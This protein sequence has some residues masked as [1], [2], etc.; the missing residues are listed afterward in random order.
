MSQPRI[1]IGSE[2]FRR[3]REE[4]TLY[5]DKTGLIEELL[6]NKAEVSLITRPRRFGKTLTMTMLRD[7]FDIRQDSRAI[8]EGLAI[9]QNKPLCE[10]WMNQYPTVFLTLK[11]VEGLSFAQAIRK[12]H[13]LISNLGDEFSVLQQSPS[14][15]EADKRTLA[16]LIAMEGTEE[17]AENSLNTLC[18]AL[19]AHYG[20]PVILLIDE[21]DVPLAK[22][23]ENGYY[24]EMVS[25][26]RGFLGGALKTNPSL[27]LAVLTGCLRISK[28]SIFTGLNNFRCY[29]IDHAFFADKIGFTG[30]DVD[31]L[32]EMYGLADKKPVLQEWYDGYRFGNG[33]EMYCPWDVL[34]YVVDAQHNPAAMPKAY[35]N[36]SSGN[37][38]IRSF[39][40]RTDLHVAGKFET[41]LAGGCVEADIVEG[42]TY[43]ALYD[44]EDSLWTLLYYTGYLTK[45]RPE[46]MEQCGI[47]PG[48]DSTP[49]V[50]PNREVREIF[51]RSVAS[52]FR[53]TMRQS[54]RT[55]LFRMFWAGDA[56]GL[57]DA[58]SDQLALTI[59]YHDA[60]EDFYHAFLAGMLSFSAYEVQSNRES[61]NGRPDILVFDRP[62]KK[63]A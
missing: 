33:V 36:N 45:A 21:Y 10:S 20:K 14:V 43:D 11:G 29:G 60:R 40:G 63:A 56:A 35:W 2:F 7:F 18:R 23:Q 38:I 27:A 31:S 50:I 8:F 49:L 5:M 3:I 34:Q 42:L 16:S 1:T 24:R 30:A 55:E 59:S 62:G 19:H 46:Q 13:R 57:T 4:H 28:E 9:S 26:L 58:L 48:G 44:D 25:F 22:A 37:A 51:T 32:L 54:D 39:V 52:W 15:S 6:R 41:L 61:G 17:Q 47:L 12:L 53:D